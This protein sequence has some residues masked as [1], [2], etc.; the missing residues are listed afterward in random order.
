MP[1]HLSA[2]ECAALLFTAGCSL[3]DL[4]TLEIHL[5]FCA[6]F[7]ILGIASSM[8]TGESF[9]EAAISL[10]PGIALLWTAFLSR[11]AVGGGDGVVVLIAGLFLGFS[12]VLASSAA[13]I[14]LAGCYAGYCLAAGRFNRAKFPFLPFLFAGE[15]L[16]LLLR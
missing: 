3:T 1:F 5:P 15:C 14:L 6:A 9:L 4:Q 16:V 7:L 12:R 2:P 8:E 13:G 10:L 11:G